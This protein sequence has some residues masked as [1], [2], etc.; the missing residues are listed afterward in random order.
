M[1][2]SRLL[3]QFNIVKSRTSSSIDQNNHHKIPLNSPKGV[4]K[5]RRSG[6]RRYLQRFRIAVFDGHRLQGSASEGM[7]QVFRRQQFLIKRYRS[8]TFSISPLALRENQFFHTFSQRVSAIRFSPACLPCTML[9]S[10]QAGS[11]QVHCRKKG[12][13]NENSWNIL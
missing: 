11:R 13:R 12:K 5:L 6:K 7:I 1:V 4:K 10:G 9:G 8:K 2:N 3:Y